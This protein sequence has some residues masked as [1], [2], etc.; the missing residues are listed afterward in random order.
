MR[1]KGSPQGQIHLVEAE[2][3]AHPSLTFY[4]ADIH[5][6]ASSL[7]QTF[8]CCIHLPASFIASYKLKTQKYAMS[9]W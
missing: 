4:A 9:L 5:T 8:L 2:S 3:F 6:L 7:C 1:V